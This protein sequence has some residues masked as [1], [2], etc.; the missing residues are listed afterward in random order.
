MRKINLN[1]EKE[2]LFNKKDKKKRLILF[3]TPSKSDL[4]CRK[5]RYKNKME[6]ELGEKIE[7]ENISFYIANLEA[8]DWLLIDPNCK[9]KNLSEDSCYCKV[10]TL[11]DACENFDDKVRSEMLQLHLSSIAEI[12]QHL[13]SLNATRGNGETFSNLCTECLINPNQHEVKLLDLLWIKTSEVNDFQEAYKVE[14][15]VRGKKDD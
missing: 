3:K 15:V 14:V 4:I 1:Q 8:Q 5:I 6:E 7:L 10:T 2:S 9:G 13:R 11:V 12:D